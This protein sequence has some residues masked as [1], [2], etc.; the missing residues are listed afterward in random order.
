MAVTH[1]FKE[2][3]DWRPCLE[4]FEYLKPYLQEET[5]NRYGK[6]FSK[7]LIK[8]IIEY[9]ITNK[10]DKSPTLMNLMLENDIPDYEV[11]KFQYE[12]SETINRIL[13]GPNNVLSEGLVFI[14]NINICTI[15][16]NIIISYV[17][18]GEHT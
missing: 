9:F 3:Y 16:M 1:S 6:E 14:A 2:V 4:A 12:V 15:T 11:S 8:E 5:A 13:K 17:K 7:Y 10:S 18:Y